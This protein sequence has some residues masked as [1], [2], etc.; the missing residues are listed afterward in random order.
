[1]PAQLPDVLAR[2]NGEEVKKS[3][4]DLLVENMELNAGPGS[5]GAARRGLSRGA[6]SAGRPT[7][8]LQQEA[9]ESQRDGHGRGSRRAASS[10][11][12]QFPTE[13]AFKKALAARNMTIDR[14]QDRR[15][16]RHRDHQDDRGRGGDRSP[17]LMPSARSSTTRIPTSSSA[18]KSV[19]ASHI[20]ILGGREGGRGDEEE[21]HGRRSRAS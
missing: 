10:R 4:F 6:R 13:E 20:L 17:P 3:D 14:L 9:Q 18:A 1:M 8:S 7:R 5:R 15:A 21:G 2:V 11:C 12:R 16:R 19:R